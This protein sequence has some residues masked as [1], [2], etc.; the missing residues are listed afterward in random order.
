MQYLQKLDE[1]GECLLSSLG[2]WLSERRELSVNLICDI[3]SLQENWLYLWENG[4]WKLI[5]KKRQGWKI[6][7]EKLETRFEKSL[8][9]L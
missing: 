8:Q 9:T 3:L 4:D 6:D 1:T 2:L 5:G 7:M